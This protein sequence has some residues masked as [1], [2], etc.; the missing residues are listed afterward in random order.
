VR[1]SSVL[2]CRWVRVDQVD[3]SLIVIVEGKEDE[4]L[5]AYREVEKW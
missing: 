2:K 3:Q 5:R 4:D 1:G